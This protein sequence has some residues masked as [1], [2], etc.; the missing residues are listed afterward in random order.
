MSAQDERNRGVQRGQWLLF[1]V[2]A[3]VVLLLAAMW[4]GAGGGNN[5]PTLRG[6]DAQ[7]AVPGK[8]EAGWVRLSE[9]R[10]GG[11][12]ARLREI[13]TRNRGLEQDNLRLQERLREDA[14]N[15]RLVIDRQAALIEEFSQGIATGP[16]AAP[17]NNPFAPSVP[18]RPRAGT[19]GRPEPG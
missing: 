7:L 8:A 1:S 19:P 14:E 17:D 2:L 10:L 5:A 11:I 15:A 13:E 9:T 3:G 16:A 6:I 12:E 18:I 4:I